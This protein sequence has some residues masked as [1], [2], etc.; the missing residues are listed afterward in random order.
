MTKPSEQPSVPLHAVTGDAALAVEVVAETLR[1]GALEL[2]VRWAHV[3]E[4]QDPAPYLL[5]EELLLT[6]GVNLP[7][8]QQQIDRYVQRLLA[9]GVSALGFGV[10]PPMHE[11]LPDPLREA[12]V[13][14]GLPLLVIPPR[15]PFLAISRAVAV[16]ISDAAQRER[17]RVAE[18][19]EALT[20]SAGEGLGALARRLRCWVALVGADDAPVATS[21]R[22]H[23]CRPNWRRCSPGCGRARGAQR[24]RRAGRRLLRRRAAGVPAGHRVAAA[25]GRAQAAVRRHRARRHRGGRGAAGPDRPRGRRQRGA[26]VRGHRAAARPAGG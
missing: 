7:S 3:S 5:G 1:P 6:A 13:R 4:L 21:P 25:R 10:T 15:T 18:A 20:R 8:E 17:S 16:A 19:R 12:C 2:P 11:A 14:H 26:R 22:A 24:D 23:R 9:A